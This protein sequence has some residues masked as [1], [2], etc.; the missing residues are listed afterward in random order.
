MQ[1]ARILTAAALVT[2]TLAMS[3]VSLA[4]AIPD[5]IAA[6]VAD[7]SRPDAD[8]QRDAERKP[9]ETLAFAGV[10]P[11]DQV[12]ELAPGG[13]YYTRLLSLVVGPKGHVLA[14][15]SP[16]KP[17]RPA[18]AP[19]Y[20]AAVK[21]IAADPHY[22]N[23]TVSEQNMYAFTVP[24]GAGTDLVWTSQNYHDFHNLTA[25]TIDGV[26]RAVNAALK[27]GGTYFVLDHEAEPGSGARDTNTLHRIDKALVI[28]EAQAAGFELK[29]ESDLLVNKADAHTAKVFDASI[30]GH[31]DQFMLRF[32][33]KS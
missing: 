9:A 27:P 16:P 6:A 30:Q 23:V 24:A 2:V 26:N 4:R 33:K 14:I 5:Y 18:S 29:G 21:A 17:D 8:K 28:K 25:G 3:S 19:P 7:S 1:R 15:M 31:T 13:G 12:V 11:G 20:G 10:K 32:R 22:A